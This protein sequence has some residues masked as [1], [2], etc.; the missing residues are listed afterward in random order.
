MHFSY[1]LEWVRCGKS[2]C[3]SCPHGPYWYGYYWNGAAV[4]KRYFGRKD[5]RSTQDPINVNTLVGA[6]AV[7]GLNGGWSLEDLKK[8]YRGLAFK[9]H[10]DRGGDAESFKRV[11]AAFDY[12]E[13]F[14]KDREAR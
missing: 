11:K 13:P 1:R 4:R 3:R 12:L 9:C 6:Q 10:P 2:A 7:L 14:G 8:A 5:P